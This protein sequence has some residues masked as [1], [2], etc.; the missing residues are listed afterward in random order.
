MNNNQTLIKK[1]PIPAG[2]YNVYPDIPSF[3]TTINDAG[4]NNL[5]AGRIYIDSIPVGQQNVI[6][7][8]RILYPQVRTL[9]SAGSSR[10][11]KNK[12]NKNK[13]IRRKSMRLRRK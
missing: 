5:P 1:L 3:V 10:R 7:R 6:D 12:K 2:K 4:R 13:T 9:N 11:K 8:G